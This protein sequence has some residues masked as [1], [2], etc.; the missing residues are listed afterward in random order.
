[1]SPINAK[2]NTL[3]KILIVRLHAKTN[4]YDY[5]I[6]IRAKHFYTVNI[7]IHRKSVQ[8]RIS[9]IRRPPLGEAPRRT[10]RPKLPSIFRSVNRKIKLC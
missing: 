1:M 6:Q 5:A 9:H 2:H 3:L 7:N 4:L 10:N 8:C